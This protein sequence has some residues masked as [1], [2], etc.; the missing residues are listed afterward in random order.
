MEQLYKGPALPLTVGVVVVAVSLGR[1]TSRK[2]S[3]YAFGFM[4]NH[5]PGN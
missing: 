1:N 5:S 4:P 2:S 3:S